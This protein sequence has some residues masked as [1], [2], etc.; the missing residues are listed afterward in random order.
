MAIWLRVGN[1]EQVF[2]GSLYELG[3]CSRALET[4]APWSMRNLPPPNVSAILRAEQGLKTVLEGLSRVLD[5][6]YRDEDVR[7]AMQVSSAL[8]LAVQTRNSDAIREALDRV[9]DVF[10]SRALDDEFPTGLDR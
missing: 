7:A 2:Q 9:Q 1:T 6:D 10:R 8:L 5:D 3:A 4:H